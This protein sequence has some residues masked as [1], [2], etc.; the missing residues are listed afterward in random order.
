VIVL[1]ALI[2][3]VIV[4]VGVIGCCCYLLLNISNF[5]ESALGEHA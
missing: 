2:G 4:V 5:R 3:T 1:G